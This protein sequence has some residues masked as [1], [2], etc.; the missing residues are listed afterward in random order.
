MSEGA[1]ALLLL[2]MK[3]C[4]LDP[5]PPLANGGD[6]LRIQS[7]PGNTSNTSSLPLLLLDAS[8]ISAGVDHLTHLFM[9][10]IPG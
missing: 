7:G 2:G 6:S 4:V 3:G 1:P 10:T 5:V 9:L 8:P